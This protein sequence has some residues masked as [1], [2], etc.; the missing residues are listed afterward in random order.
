MISTV[1]NVNLKPVFI[2]NYDTWCDKK[3]RGNQMFNLIERLNNE[4]LV[5]DGAMG[6]QLQKKCLKSGD[7]PENLNLTHPEIIQQIHREYVTAGSDII[8]TNT[9]GASEIK[10]S[11]Y[12]LE[13]KFVEINKTAVENA[14]K[15]ADNNTIISAS[16]GPTGKLLEPLGEI[17]FTEAYQ[18][19]AR[20]AK[21]LAEAGADMISIETMSDLQELRAAVIAVKEET[22]L[23]LIAHLTFSESLKTMTGT[24]P[25]TAVTVLEGL[26]VEV[27]GANCSLGP[28]KLLE[29]IKKM[30][31]VSNTCLAVQP[32]AGL[33]VLRDGKTIYPLSAKEMAVYI[34][35]F[36]QAGVNIIGGCCGTGP[37]YIN[38]LSKKVKKLT[39]I[40]K[41]NPVLTRLA[42]R[43]KTVIIAD[44]R[45]TRIIGE[46]INPTGR[47]KLS[48]ELKQGKMTIL[49][50]EAKKQ[51]EAGASILDLNIG[52]PEIDQVKTM[53]KA[54]HNLQ[55]IVDLPISLDTTD[56][57]V[58]ETGL[59]NVNGKPLINSVTGEKTSLN[60]VL[61]LAKKYGAAILGL[62]LDENGIPKTAEK[63][64][65]IARKIVNHALKLGI[66]KENIFID[67]LVLT[68]SAEQN[69]VQVTLNALKL[70]KKELG[71]V[72]VLGLSNVSYGLPDREIINSAYLAMAIKAGLNAPI[73]DPTKKEMIN[74]VLASDLLINRDPAGE[75]YISNTNIN[76]EQDKNISKKKYIKKP[77]K[78]KNILEIIYDQV[79]SGNKV[80]I[81]SSIQKALKNHPA[82]DIINKA[83]IP[84]IKKVGD[85]YDQGTFYL[86]QLMLSAETMQEAFQI[87]KPILVK[88]KSRESLAKIVLATVKGDIHDIGKN[89]V[90][91]MLQ[92]NGFEVIDLGKDVPAEK[93]V[94]TALKEDADIVGLSALMTT[95]MP[96]MKKVT[97]KLKK[98]NPAIKVLLGGA[99]VT[100]DY[101]TN[102]GADGYAANAVTAVK[103]AK[104][105]IKNNNSF[106]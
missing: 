101:A 6:T 23:P 98:E 61:P 12:G 104:E 93:I 100:E 69:L 11:Q 30:G 94:K 48:E 85:K 47:K 41:N 33:P 32:N 45:P 67:T 64:L 52:V 16:I 4:I 27:I 79:L 20:Q 17:D 65:E 77:D 22:D 42:S 1:I 54:V 63:R 97:K 15:A 75:R 99:V 105:L 89:I 66:K 78:E 3:E 18:L 59:Q 55:R 24:D 53:K 31:Q 88:E 57:E 86:P 60:T 83:L 37:D 13:N 87:L 102:I 39:P 106:Q 72:T 38:L 73:L 5:L 82:L 81:I 95:T 90:K 43:T 25:E 29:I 96:E 62:T 26:G 50:K 51:A 92:N 44:D 56:P 91:V 74:T 8:Q 14:K 71:V 9:F 36:I 28:E 70:I 46:R 21:V 2:N 84:G 80:E 35:D 19:F 49:N 10:L 7:C 68:A 76:T 103:K 34:Q 58:L 40:K